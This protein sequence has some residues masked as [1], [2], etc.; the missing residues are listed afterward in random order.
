MWD[1]AVVGAGL[2]GIVCARRLLAAGYS[3][4]ILDKS[5]GLGG[6]IATRRVSDRIR[7][8]HGLRYWQPKSEAIEPLTE[9]LIEAGVLKV[10]AHSDYEIRK[11]GILTQIDAPAPKYIS[12]DGMS[13]IS[14]YL[15]R[16]FER[17]K[18][19][20]TNHRAVEIRREGE[21]WTIR[22][23]TGEVVKA[24]KCAIAI[25][26]SQA[27]DLL[28]TIQTEPADPVCE[29]IKPA[30][31]SLRAVNYFPCLTVMAGYEQSRYAEMGE[32]D[33]Q[34]W[35][36]T[37]YVGTSTDWIALDSSKRSNPKADPVIVIHSKPDFAT[38]YL[39]ATD[40]QPAASVLLRA[41]SRRFK[42]PWLAQP[43]WFQIQRWRYA[44]VKTPYS[45][46]AHPI[47]NTLICGGDWCVAHD[48]HSEYTSIDH[49]YR[50]G[51]SLAEHIQK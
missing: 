39:D 25:P 1:V 3:V 38:Q 19:L 50:S 51:L 14:K 22:C 21:A 40:T 2:S 33:S 49:A 10:W 31:E 35:A 23:E 7:V 34:G 37:D 43:E 20:F 16:Q 8:D 29:L 4:C 28:Q 46:T 27:A 26:A 45:Q 36:V 30:L 48:T 17:G 11:K 24:K 41:N 32:L 13:A 47:T 15:L 6:R 12:A 44:H 5:R 18:N 9:E 42:L